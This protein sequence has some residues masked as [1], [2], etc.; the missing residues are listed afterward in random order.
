[1]TVNHPKEGHAPNAMKAVDYIRV[2]FSLHDAKNCTGVDSGRKDLY[3]RWKF[4]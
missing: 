3:N 1:M 4:I 2:G